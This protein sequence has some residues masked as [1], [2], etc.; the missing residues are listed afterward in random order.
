MGHPITDRERRSTRIAHAEAEAEAEAAADADAGASRLRRRNRRRERM[1]FVFGVTVPVENPF[2]SAVRIEQAAQ[3]RS[4]RRRNR[5]ARRAPPY[6][7]VALSKGAHRISLRTSLAPART[8]GC[9]R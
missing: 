2:S 7:I 9:R 3:I 4:V 5:A 6:R 1:R 8:S